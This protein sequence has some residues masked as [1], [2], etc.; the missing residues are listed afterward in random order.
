VR[1]PVNNVSPTGI[2]PVLQV[3]PTRRCNL[4]CDHC[5]SMS[6]PAE[7]EDLPVEALS[8]CLEDAFV[9]G[10]RQLAVSG[11]EPLLY[12]PLFNL[13]AHSR[14]MGML[15]TVTTNGMLIT[16]SRWEQ[17]ARLVDV[18]AVSI[19][20]REHEHD[21]IRRK[22]G[23]FARTV[24]NLDIIR[25]SNVPFGFIFT[26]TQFNVDSLEFVVRLA[27]ETGARSVQVHPLTLHG[28]AA[29]TM[30]GARPDGI[31]LVAAML[32]A[33]RFGHKLGVPVTVD[34]LS[35]QQLLAYRSHLVPIRP[36]GKLTDVASVLVVE[37]D[38]SVK[39]L[40]HEVSRRLGL[41]S[42]K[43]ERLSKLAARWL[44]AGAGD[45]LAD[46]CA[47]TWNELSDTKS[48]HAVYWYDEVA[49]RTHQPDFFQ[50]VTLTSNGFAQAPAKAS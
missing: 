43:D 40:T 35:V 50:P 13:L 2:A 22:K 45:L 15:N 32:E 14:R 12:K 6:G 19:D 47:R 38:G 48:L 10:Y 5:Y 17:L 25:E 33:V 4:L 23:A 31:E 16:R 20:G 37:P 41:G 8:H 24:A 34:A 46:A 29:L 9:L 36:I 7:R 27:R 28:R 49:A 18:L 21:H 30:L 11:G 39:P 3:H 26:L 42:L 44:A 1:L